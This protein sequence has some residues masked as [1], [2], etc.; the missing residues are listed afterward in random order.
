MFNA[1]E[2]V[3]HPQYV[4]GLSTIVYYSD[5]PNKGWGVC[6]SYG[7]GRN[8]STV[9]Y[10]GVCTA[11]LYYNRKSILNFTIFEKDPAF[12]KLKEIN[13]EGLYNNKSDAAKEFTGQYAQILIK[14]AFAKLIESESSFDKLG[15]LF[16]SIYDNGFNCG[17][18]EIQNQ[19]KQTLNCR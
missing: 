19:I 2:I 9:Y 10:V 18:I 16:D 13:K 14:Y 1:I 15:R 5:E 8:Q 4:G 11:T 3:S 6:I 17:K 12:A 7:R